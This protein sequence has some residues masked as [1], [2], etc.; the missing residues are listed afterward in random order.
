MPGFHGD[1]LFGGAN[2]EHLCSADRTNSL[3][4]GFAV[5]HGNFLIFVANLSLSSAFYTV[6]LHLLGSPPFFIS[7]WIN[8]AIK[9]IPRLAQA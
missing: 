7:A 5:F 8:K 3:N 9:L 6:D 4:G 2:F 1:V